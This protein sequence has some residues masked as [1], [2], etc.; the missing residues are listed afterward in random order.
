MRRSEHALDVAVAALAAAL[1]LDV[2]VVVTAQVH[3]LAVAHRDV[4]RAAIV[5]A[6]AMAAAEEFLGLRRDGLLIASLGGVG[7]LLEGRAA[8]EARARAAVPARSAVVFSSERRVIPFVS[9]VTFTIIP[10]SLVV[11]GSLRRAL[12]RGRK[13][14]VSGRSKAASCPNLG[15]AKLV[16]FGTRAACQIVK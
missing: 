4:D 6:V 16:R 3:D 2:A 13:K 14:R 1:L 5:V 8:D 10:F 11:Y 12:C 9:F 7:Q 15:S